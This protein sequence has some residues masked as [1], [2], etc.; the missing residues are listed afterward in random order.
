MS[1]LASP[2]PTYS[3]RTQLLLWLLGPIIILGLIAVYDGYSTARSTADSVSDRVLAGSALAI[4]E[5]V[6]VNEDD[7]LEVDIPYVALQML[8]SSEDDRV[9]YR[10]ES[11]EGKFVTGY[12]RLQLP[13]TQSALAEVG[14][15][16]GFF[17]KEPIRLAV[18]SG[19][20][21][22]N[23]RSL[24][25]RVAV[26][27]TTNTRTAIAQSILV[28]S[29][30]RQAA[31][32][33]GSTFLVWLVVSRALKP[34]QKLESAVARR[35]PDDVRPIRHHVPEEVSGLVHTINELVERFAASITALQHFTSNASHQF[36]T[37]LAL[38]KTHLEVATREQDP[39]RQR[40]A[41]E[42]AHRAV[43]EAER[44]MA[45]MLL[46]A[47]LDAV[48]R[49]QIRQKTCD[50]TELSR[51]T[52]EEFVMQLSHQGR[53]DVDL[54]FE[55]SGPFLV[56]ADGTL[57][58]EVI[59]NLTDNAIKHSG[60]NPT[61]DVSVVES[62]AKVCLTVRDHGAG[63]QRGDG[64]SGGET[65]NDSIPNSGLNNGLGL[66]IVH[67]ILEI[68]N[69]DIEFEK[70]PKGQGMKVSVFFDRA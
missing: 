7:E 60:D 25:F 1:K 48:S 8:T 4:A 19:A 45:Q 56:K 6:F 41:I 16:N 55:A 59:R 61:I 11:D 43:G 36:R 46:L 26:A 10:I 13:K 33:L 3:L 18:Y 27:E 66:S 2:K 44:L 20:A 9:F 30:W 17:R 62:G 70:L 38:I 37:P 50:L 57:T 64:N 34:L 53:E 54:G 5:R 69:A 49:E 68:Q 63:F 31:L 32:I 21:S 15:S 23:T 67:E 42:S 35:S 52:C 58:Q 51:A 47:R 28:R 12:R 40:E 22:S 39:E 65:Q 24:G 14:F 29:L